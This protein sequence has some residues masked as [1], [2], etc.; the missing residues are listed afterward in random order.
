[1]LAT[2]ELRRVQHNRLIDRKPI[3]PPEFG[4][5]VSR[6]RG[7]RNKAVV[8]DSIGSVEN[9]AVRDSQSA[10]VGAIRRADR[11]KR[12]DKAI[13]HR[14]HGIAHAP[15]P[16]TR[17][18]PRCVSERISTGKTLGLRR[19]KGDDAGG[20]VVAVKPDRV[21]LP[22]ADLRPYPW[23][24][25]RPETTGSSA[26]VVATYEHVR[27]ALEQI[28]IPRHSSLEPRINSIAQAEITAV[29]RRDFERWV[30]IR[31]RRRE[32]QSTGW[33]A[34][35]PQRPGP[36]ASA[37]ASARPEEHWCRASTLAR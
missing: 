31:D 10:V 25:Q 8:V 4:S 15:A 11:Q 33:G 22:T 1:M 18:S 2:N 37:S 16:D 12:I 21:V 7:T 34:C 19:G 36:V 13:E 24:R 35:S 28:D 26:I 17:W 27:I 14:Q 5:L 20:V 9:P 6:E 29:E 30:P 23:A 3:V 32:G